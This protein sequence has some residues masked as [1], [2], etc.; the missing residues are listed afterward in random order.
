MAL[1]G[2][3]S[4]RGA[5]FSPPSVFGA[6]NAWL[7]VFQGSLGHQTP[8]T[9]AAGLGTPL[10]KSQQRLVGDSVRW[11]P[12]FVYE[13][14]EHVKYVICSKWMCKERRQFALFFSKQSFSIW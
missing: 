3:G 11:K 2:W 8:T 13:H 10:A 4:P 12:F 1:G 5:L 14:M 9:R 7:C 6:E